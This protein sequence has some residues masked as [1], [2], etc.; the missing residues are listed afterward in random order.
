[1]QIM[2]IYDDNSLCRT[3]DQKYFF[4][5]S[6]IYKSIEPFPASTPTSFGSGP[7]SDYSPHDYATVTGDDASG[8][9]SRSSREYWYP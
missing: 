9:F 5:S 1:M 3:R 6:N 2:G 4:S 7:G 8:S